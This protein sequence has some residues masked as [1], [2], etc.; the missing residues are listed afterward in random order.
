MSKAD[1][2]D[3]GPLDPPEAERM[4]DP[5][6]RGLLRGALGNDEP[7]NVDVLRGVQQKLRQRSQGKFYDDVWSTAEHPPIYTYLLTSALMLAVL[8]VIYAVL[9]PTAGEP[10]PVKNEP[11]P[12]QVISPAP[13]R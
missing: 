1:D 8:F 2:S 10:I 5:E 11:A 7:A 12:V 3:A 4:S 6:L 9:V 13:S